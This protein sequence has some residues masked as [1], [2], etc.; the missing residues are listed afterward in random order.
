MRA[1]LSVISSSPM[2]ELSILPTLSDIAES[3]NLNY[4]IEFKPYR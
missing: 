3:R 1:E 2:S 4:Q